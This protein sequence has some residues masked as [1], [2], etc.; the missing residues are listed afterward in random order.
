MAG[1]GY[2]EAATKTAVAASPTTAVI[3][4]A[5]DGMSV[6][7]AAVRCASTQLPGDGRAGRGDS[8][9]VCGHGG[10]RFESVCAQCCR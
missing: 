1:D 4:A 9:A 7:A 6:L 2:A 3:S 5:T 10:S 8:R